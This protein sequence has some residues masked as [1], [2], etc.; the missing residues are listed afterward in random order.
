M[1]HKSFPTRSTA[2]QWAVDNLTAT[3]FYP[4]GIPD[5]ASDLDPICKCDPDDC[6]IIDEI[7]P[8]HVTKGNKYYVYYPKGALNL[9]RS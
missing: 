5:Y 7:D 6:V 1:P 2:H 9:D 3:W 8:Y 4:F